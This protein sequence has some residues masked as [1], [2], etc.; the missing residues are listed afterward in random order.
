MGANEP[1]QVTQGYYADA[2]ELKD[3]VDY[4]FDIEEVGD[5]E[6]LWQ[7]FKDWELNKEENNGRI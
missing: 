7:K 1:K 4:L 6:K 3:F 2:E 5:Y